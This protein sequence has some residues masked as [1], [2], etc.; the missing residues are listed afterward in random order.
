MCIGG[1]FRTLLIRVG[2]YPNFERFKTSGEGKE[3]IAKAGDSIQLE[4]P[5]DTSGKK[6]RMNASAKEDEIH[7]KI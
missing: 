2:Y 7:F 3:I 6:H 1:I 5:V 4:C